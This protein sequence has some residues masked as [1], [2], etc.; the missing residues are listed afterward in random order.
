MWIVF[1]WLVV[2]CWIGAKYL[3]C[4]SELPDL[5]KTWSKECEHQRV[6]LNRDGSDYLTTVVPWTM[7]LS[8]IH[9]FDKGNGAPECKNIRDFTKSITHP[10]KDYTC[11]VPWLSR[12]EI[13]TIIDSYSMIFFFGDS[14]TRHMS[15]A[16]FIL[17]TQ[18]LKWGGFPARSSPRPHD[19]CTCDGQF[20]EAKICREYDHNKF[21]RFTDV[22]SKTGACKNI[23]LHEPKTEY[24]QYSGS[25]ELDI[26]HANLFDP[27]IRTGGPTLGVCTN[28]TRPMFFFIQGGAHYKTNGPLYVDT[29]LRPVLK[30]IQKSSDDCHKLSIAAGV[31]QRYKIHIAFSGE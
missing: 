22:V 7:N 15:Q 29:Y 20:D 12:D 6:P 14:L 21:F 24:F 31:E 9:D 25:G 11:R 30:T 4:S 10:V 3:V 18:D 17:L 8:L 13:C 26:I 27:S 1:C 19:F 5:I 16:L 28:D 23:K 2:A